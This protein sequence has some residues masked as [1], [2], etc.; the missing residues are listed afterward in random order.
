MDANW[1][2]YMIECRGGKIYTGITKDPDARYRRHLAGTGAAFTR[3]NPPVSML[4][5]RPCGT[6]SEAL[7]AERA[8]RRLS[9]GG[10]RIWAGTSAARATSRLPMERGKT[11]NRAD[12][13][14]PEKRSTGGGKPP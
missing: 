11:E 2:V 4:A 13:V 9:A 8:L 7:K 3:M 12:S 10:K 5:K 1:W 14:P 6:R